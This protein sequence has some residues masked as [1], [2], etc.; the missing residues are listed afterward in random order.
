MEVLGA[1]ASI[2]GIIT[3]ACKAL[4]AIDDI[5]AVCAEFSDKAAEQFLH[6]LEVTADVLVHAKALAEEAQLQGPQLKLKYR[7]GALNVQIDD[8]AQDLEEWLR[9]AVRMRTVKSGQKQAYT[10]TLFNRMVTAFSKS[11]RTKARDKLRW[12]R[13]N[14]DTTL[15]IFGR[16]VKHSFNRLYTLK[17]DSQ[18]D[19]INAGR[20]QNLQETLSDTANSVEKQISDLS[21]SISSS[22]GSIR[23]QNS[24]TSQ[25]LDVITKLIQQLLPPKTAALDQD[26]QEAYSHSMGHNLLVW[27]STNA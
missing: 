24:D 11:S 3:F 2:V 15:S 9:I 12:H 14:I 25:K 6:D 19:L 22:T 7:A 5:K 21:S 17:R 23:A 27:H 10:Q 20:I 8:C 18:L 26:A 13:E 1:T 4:S 16:S